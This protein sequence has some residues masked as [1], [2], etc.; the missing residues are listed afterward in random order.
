MP[1]MPGRPLQSQPT[2][3][4]C[5]KL[6]AIFEI[7]E[8]CV[9][10]RPGTNRSAPLEAWEGMECPEGSDEQPL[11]FRVLQSEVF[12][13][14]ILTLKRFKFGCRKSPLQE[15]SHF[16][17]WAGDVL[18]RVSITSRRGSQGFGIRCQTICIPRMCQGIECRTSS[19]ASRM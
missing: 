8:S 16:P 15:S 19:K 11:G 10:K 12:P 6:R 14:L 9:I 18:Q 13:K 7:G 2:G 17:L 1:A 4:G 5:R 3:L